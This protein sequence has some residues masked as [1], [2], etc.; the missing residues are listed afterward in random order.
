VIFTALGLLV[1]AGALLLAGIA[2]SSVLLLMLSLVAT[3]A[4]CAV[5]AVAYSVA[6][7]MGLAG[8]VGPPPGM[9]D[10]QTATVVMYVPVDQL[11]AMAPAAAAM[12]VGANGIGNGNGSATPPPLAGYDDMTAE[13][14]GKL[15]GS[16][17]L[18][19][20]QLEAVREYEAGHAARK[21][22]LDRINKV[23]YQ[24]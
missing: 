5:V 24:G 23:L 2:K 12:R 9:P 11:P 22:V 3:I 18:N 4:A 15:I 19:P 16:G 17:A 10:G 14:I 1:L 8:Q 21:T 20:A 13:Q 7:R 6:R